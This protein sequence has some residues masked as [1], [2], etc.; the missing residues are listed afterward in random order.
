MTAFLLVGVVHEVNA[1]RLETLLVHNIL[2][3][4]GYVQHGSQREYRE[5]T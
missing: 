1:R 2:V 4:S 3:G 5:A